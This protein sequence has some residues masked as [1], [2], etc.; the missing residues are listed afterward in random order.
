MA[1]SPGKLLE[2]ARRARGLSLE[3]AAHATKIRAVRLADLERDELGNFPSIVYARGFLNLYARYL[4]VDVS[5]YLDQFEGSSSVSMEGYSYLHAD[6]APTAKRSAPAV[7]EKSGMGGWL[8][9]LFLLFLLV[10]G[11]AGWMFLENLKRLG[12]DAEP[13]VQLDPTPEPV[14]PPDPSSGISEPARPAI[15]PMEAGT[16]AADAVA[17]LTPLPT[18]V[19]DAMPEVRRAIPV[20]APAVPALVAGSSP[21]EYELEVRPLGTAK[22][23]VVKNH[24]DADP[25]FDGGLSTGSESLIFRGNRFYLTVDDP[26]AVDVRRNGQLVPVVAGGM[27]IE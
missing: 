20:E 10:A 16:A 5:E 22:V 13:V 25:A 2:R 17:L 3:D 6:R 12:G 24:P 21:P 4:G 9:G 27:I 8:A 14:A 7:R 26:A 1:T 15:S 23:R 11:G 19:S 18:P